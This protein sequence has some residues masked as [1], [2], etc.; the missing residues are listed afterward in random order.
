[1][2]KKKEKKTFWLRRIVD[3]V[4]THHGGGRGR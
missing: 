1:M 2:Y 3:I 4:W